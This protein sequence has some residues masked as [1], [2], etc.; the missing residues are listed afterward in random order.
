M[1]EPFPAHDPTSSRPPPRGDRRS[2]CAITS[3]TPLG[4][5]STT[6]A[7][8]TGYRQQGRDTTDAR[9]MN[10]VPAPHASQQPR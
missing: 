5:A 3:G 4:T 10:V 2:S 1:S 9:R 7:R 6:A 8:A